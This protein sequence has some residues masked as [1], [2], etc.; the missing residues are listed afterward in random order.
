MNLAVSQ[1]ANVSP[2]FYK[3]SVTFQVTD[4]WLEIK[5]NAL[6]IV[7]V[8]GAT[9]ERVYNGTEQVFDDGYAVYWVDNGKANYT[10]PA[11]ITVELKTVNGVQNQIGAKGTNVGTYKQN[12][13]AADFEVKLADSVKVKVNLEAKQA[14][15]TLIITPAPATVTVGTYSKVEGEDDPTFTA[16][17]G[18]TFGGDTVGYTIGAREAGETAGSYNIPVTG[19]ANQ[20][21][22]TVTFYPGTLTI[23]AAEV[24]EEPEPPQASPEVIDEPETPMAKGPTRPTWS[25]F[26]LI[27]MIVCAIVAAITGVTYFKKKDDAEEDEN[28]EPV[29]AKAEGEEEEEDENKRHKSKF[30]GLIPAVAAIITFILTQDLSGLM[31]FFDK[32]SILFAVYVIADGLVAYFTRNK[33]PEEEEE[34]QPTATV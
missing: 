3:D 15:M 26:D 11:G 25:L 5:E 10:L 4:G 21:N 13:S 33:K 20:G 34:E 2:N 6:T 14:W 22:Y 32:W 12:F 8:G 30:L 19:A 7:V 29:K 31:V 17:V 1:F 27:C 18:G 24:I 28:A 23:T 9:D 16:T